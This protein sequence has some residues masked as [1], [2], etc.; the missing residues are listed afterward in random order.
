MRET[1]LLDD[2]VVDLG[3]FPAVPVPQHL[4]GDLV[5]PLDVHAEGDGE[6]RTDRRPVGRREVEL[7]DFRGTRIDVDGHHVVIDAVQL[8]PL[9]ARRVLPRVEELLR[10]DLVVGAVGVEDD[11]VGQVGEVHRVVVIADLVEPARVGVALEVRDR[12]RGQVQVDA[13]AVE[14]G[15]RDLVA[16]GV[17]LLDHDVGIPDGR[18]DRERLGI[19]VGHVPALHDG[20]AALGREDGLVAVI[21]S[22]VRLLG[23][24]GVGGL[25]VHIPVV[26][27]RLVGRD[28][29][30][31]GR[32]GL[33]DLLGNDVVVGGASGK[34]Q[35]EGN[36]THGTSSG[37]SE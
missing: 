33:G 31:V 13:A 24:S 12:D 1:C 4:A 6:G 21:L 20:E 27:L 5:R 35:D 28:V 25:G 23:R 36:G 11:A 34:E 3:A 14:S 29:G 22:L 37:A 15:H 9:I 32:R 30:D 2:L 26:R 18:E 17:A 16:G 19:D 8:L 7:E 10:V